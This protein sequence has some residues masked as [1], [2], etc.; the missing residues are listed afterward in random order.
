[1]SR[2]ITHLESGVSIPERPQRILVP[3][4]FSPESS[5]AL[6]YAITLSAHATVI[7]VVHVWDLPSYVGGG[8]VTDDRSN[9][10]NGRVGRAQAPRYAAQYVHDIASQRM[11]E[12]LFPWRDDPRIRGIVLDGDVASTLADLSK[13]YDLVVIGRR[14]DSGARELFVGSAA[15]RVIAE[16][17]CPVLTVHERRDSHAA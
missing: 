7:D 14:P 11:A 13:G 4:D 1:M 8:L 12:L 15:A 16:A 10:R 5:A 6:R 17:P 3:V 2:F 9:E